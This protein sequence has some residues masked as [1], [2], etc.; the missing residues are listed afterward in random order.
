MR[1]SFV[2]ICSRSTVR[3]LRQSPRSELQAIGPFLGCEWQVA[4]PKDE[5]DT[6][7]LLSFVPSKGL[8]TVTPRASSWYRRFVGS[9]RDLLPKVIFSRT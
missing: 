6:T 7:T 9:R 8:T 2:G 4:R 5:R 1:L 3:L